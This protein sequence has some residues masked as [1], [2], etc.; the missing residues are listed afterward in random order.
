[1]VH[2][3]GGPG[4]RKIG[5]LGLA[6]IAFYA[7]AGS[8]AGSEDAVGA[9][10]PLLAMLGFLLMPFVW[11][12]PES[13]VSRVHITASVAVSFVSFGC[14]CTVFF[15]LVDSSCDCRCFAAWF[16]LL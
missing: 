16:S 10:G 5:V 9:A 4:A 6:S 1:M 13:L 14:S 12:V 8:P 3:V 11:G 2:G 15:F 7:V